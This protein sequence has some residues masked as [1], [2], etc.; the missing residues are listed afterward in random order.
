MNKVARVFVSVIVASS[1]T[2]ALGQ[3]V[4]L[5]GKKMQGKFHLLPATLETTQWGWF[6]NAQPPVLTVES[7][8]TIMMETMMHSHNQVVPGATIEAIKKLRTDHPGRGPHTLTG[9]IYVNGAEPG[10]VLK[11]KINKIVPRA[12][13][14]NFNVPGMFGE[15]PKEYQDG[16]VKYLYLDWDR[17]V[18]EFLPGVLIPIKPFPGTIGVARKEPGQY[19]SVPPG[20]YAGNMDIRDLTEGTVLYV[21]VFV[22]GALLWSGDSHAAQGNG[23]VNL[24]AVETAYRELNVTVEVLKDMKLDMP[25]IETPKSWITMGF[26]QDL[27]KALDQVKAQTGRF[28]SEQRKLS[29]DEGA[30]LMAK[31]SDCRISQVVNIKKGIHCLSPKSASTKEDMERPTKETARY[32]VTHAKD[33]DLNKAMDTASMSMIKWLES[34]KGIARLDAYGLASAAMDCRLGDVSGAEK[35]VHCLMP[36]SLWVANAGK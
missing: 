26:D 31:V 33:A 2:A 13:A 14:T 22:P 25:R 24:T 36:K 29:P 3:S 28:L 1:A 18:T 4:A 23:E 6:N 32:Y 20:E 30:K 35:N 9:P 17:K 10:D 5:P 7:G 19:S 12:Y 27:N 21:P 8:D 16:Q 34:S 11:V 15:F